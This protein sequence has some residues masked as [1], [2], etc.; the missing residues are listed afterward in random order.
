MKSIRLDQELE[1]RL[2]LVAEMEGRSESAVIR[3]A[4]DAW[5]TA[6]L[7]DRADLRLADIIGQVSFGGG[8]ADRTSE[9]FTELLARKHEAETGRLTEKR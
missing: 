3:S 9:A 7:R 4:I 6:A 2:R 1:T 8:V 5:C